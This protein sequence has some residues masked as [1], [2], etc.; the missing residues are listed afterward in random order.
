M[1]ICKYSQ[2]ATGPDIANRFDSVCEIKMHSWV[3]L[4]N[5]NLI[6]SIQTSWLNMPINSKINDLCC[7]V[8]KS[9]NWRE[10]LVFEVFNALPHLFPFPSARYILFIY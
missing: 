1:M 3:P 7:N 10:F 6:A 9:K 4:S 2:Q 8:E 5:A